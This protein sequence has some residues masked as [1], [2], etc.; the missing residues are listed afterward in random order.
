MVAV[1]WS[2]SAWGGSQLAIPKPTDPLK[3][4]PPLPPLE[5]SVL[6]LEVTL[7]AQ[8]LALAVD[9]A[10][11]AVAAREDDWNDAGKLADRDN[12]RFL[13]RLVR[14]PF[15]Y[16]MDHDRF[17]VR[18]N[19]IRYRIWARMNR[20]D[21]VIEG[22]CGHG[23]D[24]PKGLNLV[25]RSELSWSETWRVRTSTTFSQPVFVEPCKLDE[26]GDA[27]PLLHTVLAPRLELLAQN[28]DKTIRERTEAKKRAETVWRQLQEPIELAPNQ[29][30]QFNPRDAR[31]TPITSYGTMLLRTSINLVMEPKILNGD[32]PATAELPLP[33]LQLAPLTL[34]GFHL[35]LPMVV[36]Y[37]RINR[38][39]QK[40]M[41][42][43][44]FD[45]PIGDDLKVVGVQL[46]GSGDKLI[47]ALSV[48]GGANGTLYAMGTPVV[49]ADRRTLRFINLDF[50]VDTRNVLVQSANWM[51]HEQMLSNL[52]SQATIDLSE[53]IDRLRSR[54]TTAMRGE[55]APGAHLEGAVTALHPR[56]IY[57]TT[58]GVAIHLVADGFMRLE[59]R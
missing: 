12:F 7:P 19:Q 37:E 43:Q 34:D 14:G 24:P 6:N 1:I 11:P 22:R 32:K 55:L 49:D 31:A 9:E 46:Y 33:P 13:Y 38:Q 2:T 56:G 23:E 26:L 10:F 4:A 5:R 25:T 52:E 53:P 58:G 17:E 27:T 42:G 54:L 3:P 48:T 20:Q 57:P 45:A 28:I 40:D 35:A 15:Q 36:D 30:L 39:L 29:W 50:T 44:V 41:V 51:L 18:F 8:E 59:L 21:R 16:L 47:L